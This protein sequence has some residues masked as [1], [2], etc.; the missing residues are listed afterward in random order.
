M[1]N[2]VIFL[3]LF[4]IVNSN[5][6][7]QEKEKK[8]SGGIVASPLVISWAKPDVK[9]IEN[10]GVKFGFNFGVVGDFYFSKNFAFSTGIL[11]EN[12]G[13]ILKYKDSIPKFKG[14]N[15][16]SLSPNSIITYKLKYFEIPVS[17]KGISNE[18]GNF[19]YLCDF[20]LNPMIR[21]KSIADVSQLNISKENIKNEIPAFSL[22]YHIGIGT[23]YSLPGNM[24]LLAEIIY[25]NGL[26]NFSKTRTFD[27]KTNVYR[28]KAEKVVLN[29]IALRLGI[30]F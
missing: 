9:N 19:K 23:Q 11:L 27:S 18:I 22:G 13:G 3:V 16:Y 8:F 10:D 26:T 12:L 30:L 2:I 6:Y 21:Y 4:F 5:I 29:N 24:A 7:S 1:K 17:L 28:S 15:E 25:T 14:E 20:G